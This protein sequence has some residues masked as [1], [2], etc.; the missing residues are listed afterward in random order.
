MHDKS[1]Q[2]PIVRIIKEQDLK[3]IIEIDNKVLGERRSDYWETKFATITKSPLPSLV[4]EMES[5][6][7]GF[8]FGEASGWEY[9]VPENIGWIDTIGVDPDY[10]KKGIGRLL[11][12]EL[13]NYMKKV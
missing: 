7:V 10:Q 13:L 5:E 12:K 6:V 4:A 8:I 3:R 2:E 11:I 1:T 9:G